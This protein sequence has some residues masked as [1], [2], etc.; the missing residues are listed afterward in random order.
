MG[1]KGDRERGSEGKRGG[2]SRAEREGVGKGK[3][4]GCEE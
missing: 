1:R 2:L 3:E 4:R